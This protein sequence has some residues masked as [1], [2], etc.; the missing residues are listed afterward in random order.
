MNGKPGL[1]ERYLGVR[2]TLEAAFWIAVF[3]LQ[4]GFN[5]VTTLDDLAR[6]GLRHEP[7]Q[8]VVWEFSS[9]LV[10]LVLVPALIAFERRFPVR[11]DTMPRSLWIHAAAS[12]AFS[13]L[14]V[15]AMV[16]LREAAYGSFGARYDFGDWPVRWFFEYLKDV[17]TYVLM[18]GAILVYR[19]VMLRLQG[20]ARLLD[21]PEDGPAGEPVER[22]Q[23]FLVK[24]LRKEFLVAANDIEWL[25]AQGNYVALHVRGHDYLLRSTMA[26]IEARLDPARFAR[27][28]RSYVV[29]LDL[30]A[31]I[32]PLD[33]G[34]ARIVLKDGTRLPCSRTY[35]NALRRK[36][37]ST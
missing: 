9:N 17:R 30:V 26:A 16:A 25:L 10:L 8:P 27:V 3:A 13:L 6:A 37:E 7:W 23:R 4:A 31:E 22:P 33:S 20:E 21:A 5:S 32:E 18:L 29:N 36:T 34:D 28:H 14:H 35:R 11:T 19:F 15:A 24:K 2:R 1:F 12:V